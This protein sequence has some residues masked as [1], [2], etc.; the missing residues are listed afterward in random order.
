M[1]INVVCAGLSGKKSR[2]RVGRG[3]GSGH[4]KTCGRGHKGAGSRSGTSRRALFAGGQMPIFRTVAKSGMQLR[5]KRHVSK[6]ITLSQLNQRFDDGDEV[7][8]AGL[9]ERFQITT[10]SSG[11]K[12]VSNGELTKKLHVKDVAITRGAAAKVLGAGGSA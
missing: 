9:V 6:L 7:T 11:F 3:I 4:G 2:K 8:I 12:I 5:R 10:A 1:Q